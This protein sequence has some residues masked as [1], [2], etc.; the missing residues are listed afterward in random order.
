MCVR[1]VGRG[2]KMVQLGQTE[3]PIKHSAARSQT[4]LGAILDAPSSTGTNTTVPS[5]LHL[6]LQQS[7]TGE[8]Q[9]DA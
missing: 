3:G 4:R 7:D 9:Q 8:R 6:H 2:V 5:N 1:L